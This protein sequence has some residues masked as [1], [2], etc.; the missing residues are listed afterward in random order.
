MSKIGITQVGKI[1]PKIG[2]IYQG[3]DRTVTSAMTGGKVECIDNNCVQPSLFSK[4]F[5]KEIGCDETFLQRKMGCH[6]LKN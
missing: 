1:L 6:L 3:S 5:E 2:Y 4:E